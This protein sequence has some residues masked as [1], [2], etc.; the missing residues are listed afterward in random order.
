MTITQF[1]GKKKLRL[2]VSL[3]K[4][5]RAEIQT[6]EIIFQILHPENNTL[7]LLSHFI[8]VHFRFFHILSFF[9]VLY[10]T[11]SHFAFP[12]SSAFFPHPF[13]PLHPLFLGDLKFPISHPFP[14]PLHPT[15]SIFPKPAS[16]SPHI[17]LFLTAPSPRSRSHLSFFISAF[18]TSASL[19]W[20]WTPVLSTRQGKDMFKESLCHSAP[21]HKEFRLWL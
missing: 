9:H 1:L 16:S 15:N 11:L 19:I 5:C 3:L 17:S 7:L 6:L 18:Q 10:Y 12:Y 21:I 14:Y 13:L 8:T 2:I 20:K 4:S